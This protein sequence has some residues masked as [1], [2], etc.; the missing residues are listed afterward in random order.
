[1]VVADTD[2]EPVIK[3]VFDA[4]LENPIPGGKPVMVAPI[5]PPPN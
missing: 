3:I 2:T 1:M 4:V 5:A